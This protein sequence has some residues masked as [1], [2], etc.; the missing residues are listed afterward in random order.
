MDAYAT[1]YEIAGVMRCCIAS[2][3]DWVAENPEVAEGT[4]VLCKYQSDP[5]DSGFVLRGSVWRVRLFDNG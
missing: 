3:E 2:L 4:E 5:K 1:T